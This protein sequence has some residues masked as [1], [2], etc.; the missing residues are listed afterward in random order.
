MLSDVPSLNDMQELHLLHASPSGVRCS[1]LMVLASILAHVVFPTPRGPQNRNA[2]ANW[3]LRMAFFSVVVMWGWPTTV[4]KFCGRYFLAETIN[5]SI[6]Q[7]QDTTRQT[8]I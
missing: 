5:L 4:L 2:C 3:L 8:S 1:Q 7:P 6:R